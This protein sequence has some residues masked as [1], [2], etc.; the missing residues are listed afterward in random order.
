M[1][2]VLKRC[3]FGARWRDWIAHCISI[4][5]FSININ[6]LPSGFF[7]SSRGLRQGDPLS[8]L[9]F[10]L[11]MEAF[12]RM[13][14][15]TVDSGRLLGFSVGSSTQD[16]MMVSHLLFADDTLIFCDPI[17]DQIRDLRCL[18]LCFEPASG[19]RINLSKSEM[20]PVGEV[21][22]VEELASILGCDVTSLPLKYL[23]L[24][25]SAKYKDAHMWNSVIE[26]MEARLAGW[27]R[28]YLSKGG[29]L[30]LINSILSSLP[31]YFLSLFPI[32]VGVANRL[33][34][35]QRDFLWGGIGDEFKFHLIN[36]RTICSSKVSGGLVV[37]NMVMF[38]K[39]LMGKWLWRY[40]LWRK[41]VDSKYGRMGG[42]WCSK[43]VGGSFGFGV[44]KR[45]RRGWDAFAA[46][47]RY[48]I[49]N[50]SKVL[51]WH[52]MWCGEIPLKTFFPELF[53]IARGKD[54]WVEENMQRQ[55]GTILWNILFSRPVHE[56]E[57]E[58][59]SRFLEMLYT[60]K[61]RSEGE[62]K[63][64]WIPVRKKSFQVKSYYKVVSNP[65]QSFFP[66]KSIWKV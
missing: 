30:T 44:W 15:A 61:I 64:C 38:N 48:E 63:M 17:D 6:G 46:H 7:L 35:L 43:E 3:D 9:L 50:G 32:P 59:V 16:A 26:K 36:W 34:K 33:E 31:T 23:V 19:L 20:V 54:A 53:L 51:F 12:N 11:V 22:D 2:Y 39:T 41:V 28:L 10:V 29:R 60:L 21:G 8:T 4:V 62:D 47:V 13:I 1:L 52:D 57:L 49:G 58:A 24:P 56:W 65:I 37:R 5:C 18:L 14:Y 42:G 27:K 55:N 40:A 25:L 45:I 66:W